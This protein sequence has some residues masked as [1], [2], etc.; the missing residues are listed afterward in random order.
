MKNAIIKTSAITGFVILVWSCFSEPVKNKKETN[1]ITN[2]NIVT[3]NAPNPA[4]T[5]FHIHIENELLRE[6]L[7]SH[8][9]GYISISGGLFGKVRYY[10][11]H[12]A[13]IAE[14]DIQNELIMGMHS[15]I[16]LSHFTQNELDSIASL[17][18]KEAE[19]DIYY[20]E[21]HWNLKPLEKD[22]E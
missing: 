21:S 17:T 18:F 7:V 5:R 6:V 13:G 11:P 9:W 4:S 2:F 3:K 20:K 12:T 22:A 16:V 14:T 10:Y 8:K 19:I 1:Y 15:P